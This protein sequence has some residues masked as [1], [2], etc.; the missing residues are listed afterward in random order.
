MIADISGTRAEQ[1]AGEI[2]KAGG[3]IR[4]LKMD[5]SEPERV[6]ATI[7]LALDNSHAPLL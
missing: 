4:W 2:A 1:V 6:Q 7:R 5:A 3:T